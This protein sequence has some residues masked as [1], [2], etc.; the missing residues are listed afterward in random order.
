MNEVQTLAVRA[1]L[2]NMLKK[3]WLDICTIKEILQVTNGIPNSEDMKILSLLHCVSFSDMPPELLRGLPVL[4]KRVIE[5]DGIEFTFRM[6][7]GP[8]SLKFVDVDV[9]SG[10]RSIGA[11]GV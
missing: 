3:G 4:I 1:A 9:E 5:S 2:K 10:G 8:A 6:D 11:G 7:R